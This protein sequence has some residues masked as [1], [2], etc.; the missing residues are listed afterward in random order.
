LTGKEI[1]IAPLAAMPQET[2]IGDGKTIYLPAT[3]A[4]FGTEDM[5]FRL[6]PKSAAIDAGTVLATINDS[7]AGKAP[8]LGAYELGQALPDYGPREL[9]PGMMGVETFGYRSWVGPPRPD[10]HLLPR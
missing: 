9:P 7:Y 6:K 10:L 8:D 4:E 1:E 2:R 5:D 3:V